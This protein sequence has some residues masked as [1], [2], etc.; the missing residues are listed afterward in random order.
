M[1]VRRDW[2]PDTMLDSLFRET[3]GG[4]LTDREICA[5]AGIV[6]FGGIP[7]VEAVPPKCCDILQ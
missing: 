2:K 1:R 5:N 4:A 3:A 7:T 6:F